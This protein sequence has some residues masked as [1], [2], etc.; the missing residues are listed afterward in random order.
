MLNS[1]DT[2][3]GWGVQMP[4]LKGNRGTVVLGERG[5]TMGMEERLQLGCII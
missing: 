4:H 3:G 1:D 5:D 2:S